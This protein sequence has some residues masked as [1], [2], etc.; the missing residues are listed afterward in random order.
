MSAIRE[1][2]AS[3]PAG[4]SP[5]CPTILYSCPM[6]QQAVGLPVQ[7]WPCAQPSPEPAW[8][9]PRGLVGPQQYRKEEGKEQSHHPFLWSFHEQFVIVWAHHGQNWQHQRLRYSQNKIKANS[10]PLTPRR[11][12]II[13][14][15]CQPPQGSSCSPPDNPAGPPALWWRCE[16]AAGGKTTCIQSW[17]H[18]TSPSKQKSH[19]YAEGQLL[20]VLLLDY[21]QPQNTHSAFR[22][23]EE[24]GGLP[25][26]PW[27]GRLCFPSAPAALRQAIN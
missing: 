7:G 23:G 19:W 13:L 4:I 26:A 12:E 14:S 1:R 15:H 17:R 27:Q 24:G 22:K 2:P 11:T 10:V 8:A 9:D 5:F 6:V 3:S 20:A 16:G 25:I 21:F 18:S